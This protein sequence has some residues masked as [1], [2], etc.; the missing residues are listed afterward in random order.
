MKIPINWHD[1]RYLAAGN[2]RQ[3]RA[4]AVLE[5]LALLST[6]RAYGPVVAGTI[7][8][9]IDLPTSDIDVICEVAPTARAAFSQLV[10]AQY[11]HR[12]AFRLRQLRIGGEE[13]V[14]S[15][16]RCAEMEVEVFGQA[17]P[18]TRQNAFRHLL[19]EHAVLQAGGEAWRAAVRRLKQQGLKT[20]PAFA[21]LLQ[22]PGDPYA[23]LLTLENLSAAE[24]SAW[25]ATCS[26]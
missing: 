7:P 9:A 12:P 25:V 22:L 17:L 26:V 13:S 8:R 11:G 6:L 15:S 4:Y 19:V 21:T 16:F 5:E 20:E 1:A 14:V 2:A 10:Q 23:A 24:L 3:Q 18:T